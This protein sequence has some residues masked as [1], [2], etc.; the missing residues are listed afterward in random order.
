MTLLGTGTSQGVPVIGCTCPVCNSPDPKD[1]R[2][3]T[4]ALLDWNGFRIAIDTGPDFRQQM[5]RTGTDRLDA[6]LMT[7]EHNDH[8]IGLDDIRPFNFMQWTD[9]PVYAHPR[10][11]KELRQRFS[12]IFAKENRYPGTPRVRLH[13]ITK[14]SAWELGGVPIQAIEVMHGKLPVLGFRFGDTAY[15]TDMRTIAEDEITKLQGVR[16][17]VVSALHHDKHHS[18]MNLEE[19]LGFVARIRPEEAYLI[20]IS[21]HMGRYVDIQPRLPQGVQLAFDGLTIP[22]QDH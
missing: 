22:V 17:L 19:A 8:I 16:K 1:R 6:V 14:D 7:H 2:L 3:R 10:V 15:L 12:Y 20:H 9:M 11:Q 18:H 4:A 21:H 13:T 5:L